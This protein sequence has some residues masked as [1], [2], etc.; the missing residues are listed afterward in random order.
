[1]IVFSD[2]RV[3]WGKLKDQ[4]YTR[5]YFKAHMQNLSSPVGWLP[6]TKMS[7]WIFPSSSST[8]NQR[9]TG[10]SYTILF[11]RSSTTTC[12]KSKK[13]DCTH[14]HPA[15]CHAMSL[16]PWIVFIVWQVTHPAEGGQWDLGVIYFVWIDVC[17]GYMGQKNV[18]INARTKVFHYNIV[19]LWDD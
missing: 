7:L 2:M 1:M 12:I 16:C 5:Q 6:P 9:L 13:K 4:G 14:S 19:L 15:I 3:L 10:H 8:A 11:P 18:H 17:V